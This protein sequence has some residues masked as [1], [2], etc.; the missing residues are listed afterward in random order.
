MDGLSSRRRS[1][2]GRPSLDGWTSHEGGHTLLRQQSEGR[3]SFEG[4]LPQAAQQ[5]EGWAPREGRPSLD[6]RPPLPGQQLRRVI[7]AESAVPEANSARAS[8]QEAP[9]EAGI[10]DGQCPGCG[11]LSGCCCKV[12]L[13]HHSMHECQ[14][15]SSCSSH[16]CHDI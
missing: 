5:A 9:A 4:R 6:G 16:L 15:S 11:L 10:A 3:A 8:A 7:P 14:S 12:G 1:I 13:P 2:E